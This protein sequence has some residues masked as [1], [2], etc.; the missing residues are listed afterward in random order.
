MALFGNDKE[1][2]MFWPGG[3]NTKTSVASNNMDGLL[4]H[5]DHWH[6]PNDPTSQR[7]YEI[8]DSTD[9]LTPHKDH[10]HDEMGGKV[11]L[12]DVGKAGGVPTEEDVVDTSLDTQ[13]AERRRRRRGTGVLDTMLRRRGGSS[14]TSSKKGKLL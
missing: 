9:G 5:K 3:R 4:R 6:D 2:R 7:L 8:A 1:R 12:S 10:F 14:S 11:G 13:K